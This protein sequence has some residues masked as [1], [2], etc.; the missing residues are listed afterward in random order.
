M[1][2]RLMSKLGKEDEEVLW[3]KLLRMLSCLKFSLCSPLS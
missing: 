3:E 1:M 2:R